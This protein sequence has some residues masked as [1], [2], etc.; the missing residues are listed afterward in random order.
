MRDPYEV[1]GVSKNASEADIKKAFRS[2]AKKHHPDTKGGDAAAQK[3]FQEISAAYDIVGDKEKRAKFDQGE[4]D[5]NGN[6]RGF[7][8]GPHGFGG[9]GDARDFQFQ[10]R[11]GE[12]GEGGIRAEDIFSEI[13]G[14]GGGR[15][16][17]RQARKGQDIALAVTVG[18]EEAARG[19]TRRVMLPDGQEVDVRIPVGVRDGQQIRLRGRGGAGTDYGPSGDVLLTVSVAPHPWLTRDGNN[20]RMD[21]PVTLGEAVLGGKVTVPTLTGPVTLTVPASSNSGTSLRLK[22]KGIPSHG[23]Q[24]AGDLYLRLVVTLPERPDAALE[25]FA[26]DWHP[27]YDPRAKLG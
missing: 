25:E 20:L 11:S 3:R 7:D 14:G 15:R 21:L 27:D 18:F 26:A 19:S 16:R 10:W 8:P 9:G 2:L 13:F 22:G 24:P 12:G 23:G 5:A 6:P 17:R 4:I 1:L